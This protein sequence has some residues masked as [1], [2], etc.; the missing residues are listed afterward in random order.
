MVLVVKN[1][2]PNAVD[3]RDMGSSPRSGRSPGGGMATHSSILAWGIA[4]DRGAWWVIAHGKNPESQRVRQNWS[5]LAHTS[6]RGEFDSGLSKVCL[7]VFRKI[8]QRKHGWRPEMQRKA[9][10]GVGTVLQVRQWAKPQALPVESEIWGIS[11]E[12][13]INPIVVIINKH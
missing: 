9:D 1:P 13:L 4:M 10:K 11:E 2:P 3:I 5:D 6:Y 8:T 7:L 12:Q